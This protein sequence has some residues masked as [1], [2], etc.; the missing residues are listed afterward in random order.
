MEFRIQ[1]KRSINLE[2]YNKDELD[3]AFEFSKK[4]Y[5]E[6]KSFIKAIVLFGSI[7]RKFKS[8][9]KENPDEKSDIDILVIVDDLTT[10]TRGS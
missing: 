1:K 5:N 3:T 8:I 7:S 4:V 2:K 6:F 9:N 10:N